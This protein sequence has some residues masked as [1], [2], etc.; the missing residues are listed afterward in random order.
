MQV[1]VDH[2]T[3]RSKGFGFVTFIDPRDA[4]DAV[5]DARGK[6]LHTNL[7]QLHASHSRPPSLSAM[8]APKVSPLSL[9]RHDASFW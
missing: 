6:V 8:S 9:S 4:A 3:N 7:H 2:E 1:V 5:H